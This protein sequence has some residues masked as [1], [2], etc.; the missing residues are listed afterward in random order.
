ME[1]R[2]TLPQPAASL[3]AGPEPK[4]LTQG[5]PADDFTPRRKGMSQLCGAS[6]SLVFDA[7]IDCMYPADA[8]HLV[9]LD[10]CANLF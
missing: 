1:I 3:S 4:P 6:D 2:L 9:M 7:R 8:L 10:S 5:T